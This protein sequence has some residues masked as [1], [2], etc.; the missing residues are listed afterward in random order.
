MSPI[1]NLTDLKSVRLLRGGRSVPLDQVVIRPVQVLIQLNHQRLEERREL[2]LGLPKGDDTHTDRK[3]GE[4]LREIK[5]QVA[6]S[7]T[8]NKCLRKQNYGS[9]MN[10]KPMSRRLNKEF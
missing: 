8:T 9:Y 3:V 2:A 7:R 5:W 10:R 6:D 4:R 1:R